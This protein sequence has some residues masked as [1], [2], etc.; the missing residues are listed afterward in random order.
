[1]LYKIIPKILKVSLFEKEQQQKQSQFSSNEN[2]IENS[3]KLPRQLI[4]FA[5]RIN[6]HVFR[7]AS[8]Q[9]I[10]SIMKICDLDELKVV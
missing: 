10:K 2:T 5:C 6:E 7:L 8:E 4:N 3:G 9:R 1:M